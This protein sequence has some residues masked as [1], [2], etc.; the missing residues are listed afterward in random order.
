MALDNTLLSFSDIQHLIAVKMCLVLFIA[1]GVLWVHKQWSASWLLLITGGLSATAYLLFFYDVHS[2]MF[3]FEGD[4]ITIGAMYNTFAHAGLGADFGYHGLPAF[5]P[6]LFFWL[7][8]WLGRIFDWYGVTIMKV[9]AVA[10]IAVFPFAL[11]QVQRWFWRGSSDSFIPGKVATLLA[12]LLLFVFIDWNAIILKP[13]ELIAAAGTVLWTCF[14]LRDVLSQRWSWKRGLGYAIAGGMIFMTYYLWLM[15]ATI[16]IALAGLWI[17]KKDQWRFYRRLVLVAAGALIVALPYLG[18]LF[19]VYHAHGT[20]NWQIALL[21]VDGL[22]FSAPF[23]DWSWRGLLLLGGLLTLLLYRK[24]QYIRVLLLLFLVAYIWWV[25]GLTTVFFFLAPLQEFKGF[26]FFGR[27]ILAFALAFGVEQAWL[28]AKKR[29]LSVQWQRGIAML[30]IVFL[31]WW[32]PFGSFIDDPSVQSRRVLSKR[33]DPDLVELAAFLRDRD[34]GS[35]PL[36]LHS[37]IVALPT[38]VPVDSFLYFNQHNSHPAAG[39]SARY[40][41]VESL[42][43]A[44]TPEEFARLMQEIPYGPIERLIFFT[45]LELDTYQVYVHKDG[46]PHGILE[47]ELRIQKSVVSDE[48]FERVFENESF[49]VFELR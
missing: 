16:G 30:G 37:G 46:F 2:M 49:V 34:S 18:P 8:G 44:Q 22:R 21:T 19:A 25:M 31:A 32:L 17:D 48:F 45:H 41:S 39:F 4:E 23:F 29:G 27:T 9:A 1:I 40:V 42:A 3:G 7:F 35:Y 24:H 20:E 38:F 5:Y 33:V 14:L 36:T 43:L 12:P 15:F 47:R 6:P 13:Y 26:Y 28:C 11:Y 10:T